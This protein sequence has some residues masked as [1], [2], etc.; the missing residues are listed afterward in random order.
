MYANEEEML[1]QALMERGGS[2]RL[3]LEQQKAIME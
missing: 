2:M 1:K 3:D